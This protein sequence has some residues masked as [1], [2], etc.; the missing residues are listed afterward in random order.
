MEAKSPRRTCKRIR[1]FV[2]IVN[3]EESNSEG[4]IPS[5]GLA[6][7]SEM[8]ACLLERDWLPGPDFSK[9]DALVSQRFEMS[10]NA[11]DANMY[12]QYEVAVPL[13]KAAECSKEVYKESAKYL[14]QPA[15]P[16]REVVFESQSC[17]DSYPRSRKIFFPS[18]TTDQ[19][20]TLTSRT[21]S[22]TARHPPSNRTP[23]SASSPKSSTP[24]NALSVATTGVK[25]KTTKRYNL[26]LSRCT[27]SSNPTG[28]RS[29]ASPNSS[30]RIESLKVYS[31]KD[32]PGTRKLWSADV[33]HHHHRQNLHTTT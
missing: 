15:I 7:T 16:W 17:Y 32:G 19:K 18:R 2:S 13:E 8:V 5:L 26:S 23:P 10:Y 30:T 22:N 25:P 28:A 4:E 27:N 3:R 29:G 31:R 1:T 21:I 12:D 11:P 24:P 33:N 14:N 9:R 20:C 6:A